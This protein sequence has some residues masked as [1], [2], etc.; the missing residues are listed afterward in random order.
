[1]NKPTK[2]QHA[3]L[4]WN[5]KYI[6]RATGILLIFLFVGF[7]T[8]NVGVGPPKLV[9]GKVVAI[10]VDTSTIYQLPV[11]MITI[12]LENGRKITI[13]GKRE[14]HLSTGDEVEVIESKRFYTSTNEYIFSRELK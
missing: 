4:C 12:E 8:T 5:I 3:L 14:L 6:K 1:M 10:G 11:P 7:I 9:K 2:I 13:E